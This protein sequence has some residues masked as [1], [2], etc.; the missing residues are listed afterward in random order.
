MVFQPADELY[1]P[2]DESLDDLMDG[3]VGRGNEPDVH[4]MFLF[5][6][7]LIC[8]GLEGVEV[9]RWRRLKSWVYWR[10]L[11]LGFCRIFEA[12]TLTQLKM[13]RQ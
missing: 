6:L 2:L 11:A 10:I 8:G 9:A 1:G 3:K 5:A 12:L 7:D 13:L 4:Y